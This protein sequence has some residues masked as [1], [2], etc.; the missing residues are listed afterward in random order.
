MVCV[1]VLVILQHVCCFGERDM[2]K[3]DNVRD[4][5][6]CEFWSDDRDWLNIIFLRY[7]TSIYHERNGGSSS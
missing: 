5:K 6:C 3:M 1:S 4:L 2:N 7:F